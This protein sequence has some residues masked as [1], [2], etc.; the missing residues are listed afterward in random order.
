MFR[1][2]LTPN[3][4]IAAVKTFAPTFSI[5]QFGDNR[6]IVLEEHQLIAEFSFNSPDCVIYASLGAFP[7]RVAALVSHL[8]SR[9]SRIEVSEDPVCFNNR[10]M[11]IYGGT[12]VA[13][14]EDLENQTIH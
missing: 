1:P 13:F 4:L 6:Y 10:G 9:Y 8:V 11:P 2:K 5:S 7:S 3:R 12:A 14:Y